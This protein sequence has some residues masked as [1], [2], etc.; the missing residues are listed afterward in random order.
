MKAP[1]LFPLTLIPP[2]AASKPLLRPSNALLVS[3]TTIGLEMAIMYGNWC[4]RS[5]NIRRLCC[6]KS[7][8]R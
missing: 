5:F 3:T 8:V 7:R 2:A 4:G 6:L 1:N